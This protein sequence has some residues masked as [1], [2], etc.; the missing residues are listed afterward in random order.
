MTSVHHITG[1]L[2]LKFPELRSRRDLSH[3]VEKAIRTLPMVRLVQVNSV[4][5]SLLIHYDARGT[6]QA[7]LLKAI[8]DVLAN[9]FGLIFSNDNSAAK[10]AANAMHFHSNALVD[11]MTGMIVDK[12]VERSALAILGLLI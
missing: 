3:A 9:Q 7:I 2:R 4:T 6:Q 11:R 1:R 5:G 10:A 12:I 8:Q